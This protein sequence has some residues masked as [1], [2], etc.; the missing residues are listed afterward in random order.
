MPNGSRI[1]NWMDEPSKLDRQI[2]RDKLL[3]DAESLWEAFYIAI[4]TATGKLNSAYDLHLSEER[5]NHS[6]LIQVK[7]TTRKD[8]DTEI[9]R[10]LEI[11]FERASWKIIVTVVETARRIY[12]SGRPAMRSE[13]SIFQIDADTEHNTLFFVSIHK[14]EQQ[15]YTPIELADHLLAERLLGMK[16][17]SP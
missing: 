8:N 12:T 9:S 1:E 4:Q 16:L 5:N 13:P 10:C 15:R 6:S 2:A 17:P 3:R 11:R 14:H 7:S